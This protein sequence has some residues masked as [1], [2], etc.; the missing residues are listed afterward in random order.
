[1]GSALPAVSPTWGLEVSK[2]RSYVTFAPCANARF[3]AR[4]R[5]ETSRDEPRRFD[6][7]EP[8]AGLIYPVYN[9]VYTRLVRL[10]GQP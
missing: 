2:S 7:K 6:A 10:V 5:A 8:R 4:L 1:M 9:P 3:M